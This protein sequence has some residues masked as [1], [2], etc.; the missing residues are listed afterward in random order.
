[1]VG[2]GPPPLHPGNLAP[3]VWCE[4]WELTSEDSG[5]GRDSDE[6]EWEEPPQ[7]RSPQ[8]QQAHQ[9][10]PQQQ[11]AHQQQPQQQQRQEEE[12]ERDA[13]CRRSDESSCACIGTEK[14]ASWDPVVG[15][16]AR[17]QEQVVEDAEDDDEEEEEEEVVVPPFPEN[18]VVPT[19]PVCM[20][21]V[22]E[23]EF[24]GVYNPC[25]HCECTVVSTTPPLC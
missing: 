7:P 12:E 22:T 15:V 11:Q 9:Q 23:V 13:V 25:G 8:Q 14:E 19:C 18:L 24:W 10:Q 17:E 4:C 21:A 16:G 3:M 20:A 2:E 6:C 5:E 1:M